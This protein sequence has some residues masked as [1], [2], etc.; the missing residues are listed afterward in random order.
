M[1]REFKG[2]WIPKEVWIDDKLTWMEKLFLTEIDS[3]DNEK[4]CFASNK[5]FEEF[6]ILSN[7]RVAASHTT[8]ILGIFAGVA[9]ADKSNSDYAVS[10]SAL[11]NFIGNFYSSLA[12]TTGDLVGTDVNPNTVK[13]LAKSF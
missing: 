4:H 9:A 8:N 2:V 1:N 3:L 5:Y 12:I 11:T 6:L 7:G 13:A 10:I